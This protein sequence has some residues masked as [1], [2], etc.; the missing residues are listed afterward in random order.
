[1]LVDLVVV[2]VI[3]MMGLVWMDGRELVQVNV[4]LV[5]LAMKVVE[6]TLTNRA[7]ADASDAVGP[8]SQNLVTHDRSGGRKGSKQE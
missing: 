4:A 6:G 8:P 1:M 7:R 3:W 2:M 5:A